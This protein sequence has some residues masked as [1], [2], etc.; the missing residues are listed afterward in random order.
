MA[1]RGSGTKERHAAAGDSFGKSRLKFSVPGLFGVF[2]DLCNIT[3]NTN[4]HGERFL[5]KQK[6]VQSVPPCVIIQYFG[7]LTLIHL[8]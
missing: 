1:R 2:P 5:L 6:T 8:R 7:S 4:E 3:D